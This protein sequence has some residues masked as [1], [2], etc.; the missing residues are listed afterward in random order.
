MLNAFPQTIGDVELGLATFQAA[1]KEF[2]EET[3]CEAAK[4]FVNGEVQR[5]EKR[6][7][8]SIAEFCDECRERV[9][10]SKIM[11]Q[12]KKPIYLTHTSNQSSMRL[13]R[14]KK[15]FEGRKVL[16]KEIDHTA[17]LKGS[18]QKKWP[19]GSTFCAAL[20]TVYGPQV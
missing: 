20:G 15:E 10:I 1:L 8:P 18:K 13:E 16:A 12:R 5:K 17:F 14:F 6:F 2:N 7:A 3:I 9:E 11:E 4:R 19:A